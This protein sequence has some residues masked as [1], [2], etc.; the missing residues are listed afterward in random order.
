MRW[1][2]NSFM[3]CGAVLGWLIVSSA[4]QLLTTAGHKG[5]GVVHFVDSESSEEVSESQYK[6]HNYITGS[7]MLSI[8][9][10]I[11][12]AIAKVAKNEAAKSEAKEVYL[13]AQI[14]KATTYHRAFSSAVDEATRKRA[15]AEVELSSEFQDACD[16]LERAWQIYCATYKA[17]KGDSDSLPFSR[18]E[19]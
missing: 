18:L 11:W 9:L 7:M 12:F 5:P 6:L 8:G 10:V 19:G 14:R 16:D 4:M 3:L 15:Y 2:L 13:E 1:L 17:T